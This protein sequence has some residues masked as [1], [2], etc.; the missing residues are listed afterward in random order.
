MFLIAPAPITLE[1]MSRFPFFVK[2]RLAVVPLVTLRFYRQI[3]WT[4]G[5]VQH[6]STS[7]RIFS[8]VL[9]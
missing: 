4:W 3:L 6:I 1:R 9:L 5:V 7:H 2:H 8:A